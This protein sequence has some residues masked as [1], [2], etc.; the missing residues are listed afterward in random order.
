MDS[1][2][3]PQ[4][5]LADTGAQCYL[6]AVLA[7]AV[8]ALAWAG[9]AYLT[10]YELGY[11]AWAIGGMVGWAMAKFGGR[12]NACAATAAVLAVAGIAGGK[13]L[14][15]HFL[16][17]KQ[18]R[19]SCEETFNTALHAEL[20][21][22]SVD[23]AAL[24]AD[25]SDDDLRRFM[26]EHRYTGADA[27]ADVAEEELETFL[28]MTAPQLQALHAKPLSYEEW[29]AEREAESRRFLDQDFSIVQ[30][31][32]DALNAIDLLFVLLGVTTA[33]GIVRQASPPAATP[34]GAGTSS[35]SST[36]DEEVRKAA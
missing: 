15:T 5:S 19:A 3:T 1:L 10:E 33:F 16:V 36:A 12:G 9:I 27:A 32:L 14:G 30:A 4:P 20:L 31:N 6:V 17:E 24:G 18:L 7:A 29:Y 2:S 23:Y 35:T 28:A 34:A 13:L 21:G 26:V 25:A 22:D 11:V 8:G